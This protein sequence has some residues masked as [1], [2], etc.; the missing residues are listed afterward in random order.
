MSAKHLSA[1]ADPSMIEATQVR[2]PGQTTVRSVIQN[3]LAVVLVVV[4]VGPPILEA[5]LQEDSLPEN[6]RTALLAVGAIIA[7][8]AGVL[9]RIMAIPQVNEALRRIGIGASPAQ[10]LNRNLQPMEVSATGTATETGGPSSD[11]VVIGRSLDGN[12]PV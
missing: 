2:R 11:V 12:E 8:V 3:V 6:L 1:A 10:V 4:T 5:I 9:A 7:A